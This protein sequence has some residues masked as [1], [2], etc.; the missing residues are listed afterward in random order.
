M[1]LDSGRSDFYY[2]YGK[3]TDEI[4]KMTQQPFSLLERQAAFVMP[5]SIAIYIILQGYVAVKHFY[6]DQKICNEPMTPAAWV[7]SLNCVAATCL[8]LFS[9]F[10]IVRIIRE[11]FNDNKEKHPL[12][13]VHICVLT[14]S[15][16]SASSQML[17]YVFRLGGICKDYFG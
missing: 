11:H 1:Y 4:F 15:G 10:Q 17:T 14:I 7:V 12:F 13:K 8:S 5:G 6:F 9:V 3:V 16:I 2:E